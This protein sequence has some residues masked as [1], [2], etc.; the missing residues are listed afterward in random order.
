MRVPDLR[1]V[2]PLP[3]GADQLV[4]GQAARQAREAGIPQT[5]PRPQAPSGERGGAGERR[6]AQDQLPTRANS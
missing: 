3:G 4:L 6:A 2:E 1:G 5:L